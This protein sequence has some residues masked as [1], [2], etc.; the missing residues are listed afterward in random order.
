MILY[1]IYYFLLNKADLHSHWVNLFC[2]RSSIAIRKFALFS[3]FSTRV[4][5]H[6][7]S[8]IFCSSYRIDLKN[9]GKVAGI[10]CHQAQSVAFLEMAWFKSYNLLRKR[11]HHR[12]F[13]SF[14]LRQS[15][16][17]DPAQQSQFFIYLF[18]FVWHA[19]IVFVIVIVIAISHQPS[20]ISHQ[21]STSTPILFF[22][23]G[24]RKYSVCQHLHSGSSIS[25]NS[26]PISFK[27][28]GKLA[29]TPH[30]EAQSVALLKSLRSKSYSS[31]SNLCWI[32]TIL[33][34]IFSFPFFSFVK[35]LSR[36]TVLPIK[37]LLLA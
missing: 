11:G 19:T 29:R 21:P 24:I 36:Y 15:L 35:R 20:A 28:D 16:L 37:R 23:F 22:P 30:Y 8:S 2:C 5:P 10:A 33:L 4:C 7:W 34:L 12:L 27:I 6:S 14:C 25:W 31:F 1:I 3:P 18:C 17:V 32:S 9:S 13:S 26:Y